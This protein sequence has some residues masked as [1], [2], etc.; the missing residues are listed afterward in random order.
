MNV[1]SNSLSTSCHHLI[2]I[3]LYYKDWVCLIQ[4][5]KAYWVLNILKN[6]LLKPKR[7][8][9]IHP[10]TTL[11]LLIDRCVR[12]SSANMH[13]IDRCVRLSSAN[14]HPIDRCVRLSSANM[15]PIDRCVR[16]SSA[17]MRPTKN[18]VTQFHSS[19]STTSCKKK[20]QHIAKLSNIT[21]NLD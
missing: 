12:L 15:H 4:C 3:V 20:H 2:S 13:P 21:C 18:F 6:S 5:D 1:P 16:L 11:T 10:M 9:C 8:C 17:N 14:M 7:R 19:V